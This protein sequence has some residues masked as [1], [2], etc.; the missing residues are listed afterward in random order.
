M[1]SR[2]APAELG[3]VCAYLLTAKSILQEG[4][5]GLVLSCYAQPLIGVVL[6]DTVVGGDSRVLSR[7][8][9]V[10]LE[11]IDLVV[12]VTHDCVLDSSCNLLGHV[13]LFVYVLGVNRTCRPQTGPE[14]C[15]FLYM[16]LDIFTTTLT[17]RHPLDTA[18][19]R[20]AGKVHDSKC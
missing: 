13:D 19:P 5:T 10:G 16:F 9:H 1:I 3:R 7:L 4:R 20:S 2:D 14:G 12:L 17:L 6:F 8:D 11:L 18:S 15:G